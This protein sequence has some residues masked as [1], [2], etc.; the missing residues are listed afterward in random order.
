MSNSMALKIHQILQCLHTFP[1]GE[2]QHRVAE[3]CYC[4]C[5][6]K[7]THSIKVAQKSTRV[8]STGNVFCSMQNSKTID[9]YPLQHFHIHFYTLLYAF[10]RFYTLFIRFHTLFIYFHTLFYALIRIQMSKNVICQ[11]KIPRCKANMKLQHTNETNVWW[12][13]PTYTS[14]RLSRCAAGKKTVK[15]LLTIPKLVPTVSARQGRAQP[16]SR[17]VSST[18]HN[19]NHHQHHGASKGGGGGSNTATGP[20]NPGGHGTLQVVD[21]FNFKILNACI[22]QPLKPA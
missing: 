6:Y 21:H 19:H 10:I 4:V 7:N 16:K 11:P 9:L 3:F 20:P 14:I 22:E 8:A 5:W 15:V 1:V 18:H 12:T 2:M 13:T 17:G